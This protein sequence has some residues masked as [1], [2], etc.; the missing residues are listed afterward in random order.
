MPNGFGAEHLKA[1]AVMLAPTNSPHPWH[2]RLGSYRVNMR[3][4]ETIPQLL[5]DGWT[6]VMQTAVG[7]WADPEGHFQPDLDFI[8]MHDDDMV[9]RRIAGYQGGYDKEWARREV[10]GYWHDFRDHKY[11]EKERYI[12]ADMPLYL[13][14]AIVSRWDALHYEYMADHPDMRYNPDFGYYWRIEVNG[15]VARVKHFGGSDKGICPTKDISAGWEKVGLP[16]GL[17]GYLGSISTG[18][19]EDPWRFVEGID[20]PD[21]GYQDGPTGRLTRG[22][23]ETWSGD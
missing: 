17:Y 19:V 16:G 5:A 11:Q 18:T 8:D 3:I 21:L 7:V 6:E 12:F 13:K 1:A 2:V 4:T 9:A 22:L 14:R 23:E 20:P 10:G 15:V